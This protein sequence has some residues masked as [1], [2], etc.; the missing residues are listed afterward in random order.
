MS[1]IY[2]VKESPSG[3]TRIQI[4][5]TTTNGVT[6]QDKAKHSI[7]TPISTSFKTS[8]TVVERATDLTNK[9]TEVNIN[10]DNNV[11]IPQQTSNSNLNSNLKI[12]QPKSMNPTV[13][14]QHHQQQPNA[15]FL[16][17]KVKSATEILLD[18][19]NVYYNQANNNNLLESNN[20]PPAPP[21]PSSRLN[22]NSLEVQNQP[23]SLRSNSI[24]N[25]NVNNIITHLNNNF[26]PN[27]NSNLNNQNLNNNNN[28]NTNTNNVFH[29]HHQYQNNSNINHNNNQN[30][31]SNLNQPNQTT[32]I[33]KDVI[34]VADYSGSLSMSNKPVDTYN[35]GEN[36]TSLITSKASQP[37][38]NNRIV[39]GQSNRLMRYDQYLENMVDENANSKYLA[40]FYDGR[41]F[42]NM[43]ID[44]RE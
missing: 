28:N 22:Q 41:K 44:D 8:R 24:S 10:N 36:K 39:N 32:N 25:S 43:I 42:W 9:P 6:F 17:N 5:S 33:S 1:T 18:K 15:K 38:I 40:T 4:S 13:Q 14:Q 7:E 20:P 30:N 29:Y 12:N 37:N 3:V 2:E 21:L 27:S 19:S 16:P 26:N 35:Y 23:R 11:I 31:E 34:L